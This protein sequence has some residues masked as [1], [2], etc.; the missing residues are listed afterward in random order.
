MKYFYRWVSSSNV[1][2]SSLAFNSLVLDVPGPQRGRCPV[3]FFFQDAALQGERGES[4]WVSLL[5]WLLKVT[6]CHRIAV[7]VTACMVGRVQEDGSSTGLEKHN[8]RER[9]SRRKGYCFHTLAW[10]WTLAPLCC[11]SD[12]SFFLLEDLR[13]EDEKQMRD[14]FSSQSSLLCYSLSPDLSNKC[15]L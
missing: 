15:S 12:C 6:Q 3:W 2:G 7:Y 9:K 4:V 10:L 8:E 13:S 5:W 14:W 11:K 1:P